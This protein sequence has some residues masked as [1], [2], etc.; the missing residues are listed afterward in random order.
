LE[1][2]VEEI[3]LVI[4]ELNQTTAATFDKVETNNIMLMN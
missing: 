3:T 4:D 2:T 1:V